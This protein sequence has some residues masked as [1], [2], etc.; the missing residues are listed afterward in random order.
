MINVSIVSLIASPVVG[1]IVAVRTYE[2]SV[3]K[4]R[5]KGYHGAPVISVALASLGGGSIRDGG[6]SMAGGV[7]HIVLSFALPTISVAA[8]GLGICSLF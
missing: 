5:E 6:C 2:C 3:K 4:A 7:V 1:A 8:V